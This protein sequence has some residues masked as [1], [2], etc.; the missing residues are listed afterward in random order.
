[1]SQEPMK[2]SASISMVN[3]GLEGFV[4]AAVLEL[5]AGVRLN[6]VSPVFVKETMEAM[7]MDSTHGMPAAK[8][9]LAYKESVESLRNGE[10][11]DVRKFA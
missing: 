3:A 2:G 7:G 10:I 9:A 5:G 8:V 1:L 4:R 11:L 6:V